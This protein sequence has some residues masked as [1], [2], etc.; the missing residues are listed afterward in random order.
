[1]QRTFYVGGGN[2]FAY[3]MAHSY[4]KRAA[5]LDRFGKA[6]L[7]GLLYLDCLAGSPKNSNVL[8]MLRER[9]THSPL[10]PGDRAVIQSMSSLLVEE[11]LCLNQAEVKALLDAA[12]SNPAADGRLRG[13]LNVVAMDYAAT[14]MGSVPLA[15]TYANAAVDSDPV[16]ASLRINVIHLLLALGDEEAAIREFAALASLHIAPRDRAD[17]EQLDKKMRNLKRNANTR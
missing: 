6:P 16:S 7:I 1:M 12:L 2:A 15:L 11:R 13:M 9:F 8:T 10:L 3:K 4:F 5:E 14:K 17:V